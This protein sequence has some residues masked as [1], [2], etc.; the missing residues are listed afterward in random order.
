MA[1]LYAKF[2]RGVEAIDMIE[3]AL[4]ET[5]KDTTEIKKG[6]E[7][8][9]RNE[10]D[11][12]DADATEDEDGGAG[13][14]RAMMADGA[15]HCV[16]RRGVVELRDSSANLTQEL[17]EKKGR[18]SKRGGANPGTEV[19]ENHLLH[20]AA[21]EDYGYV[22][23]DNGVMPV[24]RTPHRKGEQSALK[25]AVA[26]AM[27]AE[28]KNRELEGQ[29]QGLLAQLGGGYAVKADELK[30]YKE[31][32]DYHKVVILDMHNYGFG[33]RSRLECG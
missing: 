30:G 28:A 26:R 7:D 1:G 32:D 9:D 27:A 11:D 21:D 8:E 4:A 31:G 15:W 20:V 10:I 25:A 12:R 17:T 18:P 24:A 16:E 19:Y 14:Q 33:L 6:D 13:A 23:D 2:E 3:L 5:A 22:E 29:V